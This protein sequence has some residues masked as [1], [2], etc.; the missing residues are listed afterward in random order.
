MLIA[1]SLRDVYNSIRNISPTSRAQP[2][3]SMTDVINVT[4]SINQY[5]NLEDEGE[6]SL[7]N[8]EVRDAGCEDDHPDEMARVLDNYFNRN[9]EP[10]DMAFA[11]HSL[12]LVSSERPL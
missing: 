2:T 1:F 8:R 5:I 12:V 4:Q 6:K 3:T 9:N 11:V 7:G 10:L